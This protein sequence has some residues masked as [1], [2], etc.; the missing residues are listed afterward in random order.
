MLACFWA[1]MY[2]IGNFKFKARTSPIQGQTAPYLYVLWALFLNFLLCILLA[3]LHLLQF[4]T[5]SVVFKLFC[6][7]Q[8]QCGVRGSLDPPCNAVGLV[9]RF[10]L[11][12][13]HLYMH[14]VYKRTKVLGLLRFLLTNQEVIICFQICPC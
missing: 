9:D 13:N 3:V 5:V 12:Q 11:G 6:F 7:F 10:V 14:P 1:S 4:V 2:Q 8:V